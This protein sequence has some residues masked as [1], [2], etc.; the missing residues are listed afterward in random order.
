[1]N[2]KD[3]AIAVAA[4]TSVVFLLFLVLMFF[5][6]RL[7]MQALLTNTPISIGQII[8][9]RLRSSPATLI[10]HATIAL[11]HRGEAVTVDQVERCFLAFGTRTM[12]GTELADLVLQKRNELPH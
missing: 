7:W 3:I 4:V 2:D 12:T 1:M 6:L 9:M 10:V 5:S 11:R 8:G